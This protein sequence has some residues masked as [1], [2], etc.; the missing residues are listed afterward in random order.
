MLFKD[1]LT[2]VF[3]SVFQ[4]FFYQM[5]EKFVDNQLTLF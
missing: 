3:S 1:L 2:R 4:K 5:M